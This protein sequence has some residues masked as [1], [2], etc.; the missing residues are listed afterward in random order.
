MGAVATKGRSSGDDLDLLEERL[1][2]LA[3]EGQ[4]VETAQQV[5]MSVFVSLCLLL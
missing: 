4:S 2:S 1:Q 3:R 5:C